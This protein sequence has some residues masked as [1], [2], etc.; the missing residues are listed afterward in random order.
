MRFKGKTAVVTGGT[1]GIGKETA[2]RL[3]KEGAEVLFTGRDESRAQQAL[4]ELEKL[5]GRAY[6][7]QQDVT[8]TED[9]LRGSTA[10][11]Q[12]LWSLRCASK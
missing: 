2:V 3:V 4:Q 6:F 9:W 7:Q 8:K 12:V 11:R 10:G 5:G 1:S